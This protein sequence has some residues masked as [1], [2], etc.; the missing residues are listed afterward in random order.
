MQGLGQFLPPSL[1]WA[2]RERAGDF[3][4]QKSGMLLS[5]LCHK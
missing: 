3:L 4:S 5:G 1:V 2:I